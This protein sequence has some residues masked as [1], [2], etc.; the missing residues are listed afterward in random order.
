MA[1]SPVLILVI[2]YL[3]LVAS[4][5]G[6]VAPTS[7]SKNMTKLTSATTKAKATKSSVLTSMK[8]KKQSPQVKKMKGNNIRWAVHGIATELFHNIFLRTF[9]RIKTQL[10]FSSKQQRLEM[11]KRYRQP[12]KHE[13]AVVTGATGGIGTQIAHDLALRGYDVVVAA[14]DAKRGNALVKEIEDVLKVTPIEK[15]ISF[16]VNIPDDTSK[17]G[18]NESTIS[19]KRKGGSDDAMPTISFVE[20]HADKPLSAIDVASSIKGLAGSSRL[21]VLIN[22]AGIMGKSKRL[23]MRVNLVGPAMLTFA[24]LPLMMKSGEEGSGTPPTVINVGSSAHLRATYVMDEE[25]SLLLTEE[26]GS[27]DGKTQSWIDSLPDVDDED[28]SVYAQ[29]KLALMQFST[30]LRNWLPNSG[31]GLSVQVFDAHPGLVWTPLLRNHIGDKAVG[32]LTKTGLAGLIYKSSSEGAQAI[33]SALDYSPTIIS[34]EQTYFVN[35]QP[36]GYSAS[37]S[38]S[39]D[40]SV[41]LWK[42]ALAPEVE[43]VVELPKGWGRDNEDKQ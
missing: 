18:G 42:R 7:H 16:P 33:V 43:G 10:S 11:Q 9:S 26:D 2:L 34:K 5:Y 38:T 4:A 24:L 6:F 8:N 20:Y 36:G 21:S 39:L 13:L 12:P 17:G 14:R 15:K 27:T 25:D 3:S 35:G 29:S 22:N 40:A 30:L 41:L 19:S 32:T 31:S 1:R 23:S 28:L 37:E